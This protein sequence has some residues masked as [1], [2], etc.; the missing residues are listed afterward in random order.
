MLPLRANKITNMCPPSASGTATSVTSYWYPGGPDEDPSRLLLK[1]LRNY[2]NAEQQMR[3]RIRDEMK[4]NEKDLIALRHLMHAHQHGNALGP[5]DLSRLL[6]ISSA[7]TTALIDRLVRSGHIQRQLHPTDRRALRLIPTDKSN[8]EI[9]ETL[10]QLHERMMEVT[11]SLTSEEAETVTHYLNRLTEVIENE[12][13][14]TPPPA[15]FA[16]LS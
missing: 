13:E 16:G 14:T 6:S 11:E 12:P 15:P 5:T 8:V 3:R 7:S 1:A 2:R 9:Q 4:I 10:S